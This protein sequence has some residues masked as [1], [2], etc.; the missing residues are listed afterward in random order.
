MKKCLFI[1]DVRELT[2]IT[3]L[4]EGDWAVVRSYSE[5]MSYLLIKGMP[6]FISFDHDLGDDNY[7]GYKIAQDLC[8]CDDAERTKGVEYLTFPDGFDFSVHSANPVGSENIRMYMNNYL[9]HI[10]VK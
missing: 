6:D 8:K 4:P 1:D 3:G 2:D 5:V 10:G 9:K 7:D